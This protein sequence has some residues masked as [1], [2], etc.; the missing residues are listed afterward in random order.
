MMGME[1]GS[2]LTMSIFS[3]QPNAGRNTYKPPSGQHFALQGTAPEPDDIQLGDSFLRAIALLKINLLIVLGGNLLS[4]SS[5]ANFK[6]AALSCAG[7]RMTG[8]GAGVND[9]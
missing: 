5:L 1:S 6:T 9:T 7:L 3:I 2:C 4:I 8:I